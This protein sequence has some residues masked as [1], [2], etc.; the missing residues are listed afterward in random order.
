M[1]AECMTIRSEEIS[2]S[3]T[4]RICY[5]SKSMNSRIYLFFSQKR[6]I[7]SEFIT[8]TVQQRLGKNLRQIWGLT[9]TVPEILAFL[10]GIRKLTVGI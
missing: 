1:L 4:C 5:E 2:E 10:C 8:T 3:G 9:V 6:Y 7:R